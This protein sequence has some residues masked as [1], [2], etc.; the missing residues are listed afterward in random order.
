MDEETN[1]SL[2][3]ELRLLQPTIDKFDDFSFRIKNWFL[4]I[5]AGVASY[6]I[7]GTK[8]NLLLLNFIVIFIFYT[9]EITY[10]EA[11][12][13]FLRRSH[14]IQECLRGDKSNDWDDS[15][16]LDKYLPDKDTW[17]SRHFKKVD[18]SFWQGW[19]VRLFQLRISWVYCCALV[20][21]LILLCGWDYFFDP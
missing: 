18:R 7:V 17:L 3:N 21:N 16:Y 9:F 11:Q 12:R 6:A 1:Q 15:P 8:K 2:W 13:A 20:V 14:E 19:V 5:Y 10:R 4:I